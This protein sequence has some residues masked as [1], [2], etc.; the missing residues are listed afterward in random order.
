MTTAKDLSRDDYYKIVVKSSDARLIAELKVAFPHPDCASI[1]DAYTRDEILDLVIACRRGAGAATPIKSIVS[2]APDALTKFQV[3]ADTLITA[4]V[5]TGDGADLNDG[6][7]TP[8]VQ[9]P[10]TTV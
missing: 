9:L 2:A 4:V 6:G 7:Q 1:I 10:A 8:V 3:G 5:G